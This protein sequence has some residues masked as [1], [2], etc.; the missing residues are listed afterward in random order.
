MIAKAAV[1]ASRPAAWSELLLIERSL[2]ENPS[3]VWLMWIDAD[4]VI[5][6]PLQRLE[7]L[8][9]DNVDF[10][11][12]Q[13]LAPGPIN[14]GVFLVRNCPAVLDMLRRAYAKVQYIYHQWWEQLAI[15]EA[16][17]EC[18]PALRSRVVSRRL[19]NSLPGEYQKGDFI[20]H[21]AGFSPEAKLAGVVQAI[22]SSAEPSCQ[23]FSDPV[24]PAVGAIR[25]LL[26]L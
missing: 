5:T 1:D 6:N 23:A 13:D 8:V 9:D 7:D 4:A 12:A 16:M 2:A 20:I 11:V 22:V 21:F 15:A 25:E 26:P 18:A 10:L 17:G 19:F 14:T 24:M 3:C